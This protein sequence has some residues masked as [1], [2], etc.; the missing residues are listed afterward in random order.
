M[1]VI[2]TNGCFDIFHRGHL[3]ILK[4]AKSLGDYLIVGLNSDSSVKM[5]KGE[6]RPINN[7][8]DRKVL[9]ESLIYVDKVVIFDDETPLRLIEKVKP[10]IIVKG[11]DYTPEQV[12]GSNLAEVKIFER[13]NGY[14]TTKAI[15]D[16]V[17]R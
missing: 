9:L 5:N 17:S 4:F 13:I 1:K 15:Q 12:V 2:F 11:G 6:S 16:S 7:Q 10:D 3:E 8:E 14:S